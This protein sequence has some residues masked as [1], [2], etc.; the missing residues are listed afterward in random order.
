MPKRLIKIDVEKAVIYK[1]Q[2]PNCNLEHQQDE[3]PTKKT[4]LVCDS[5]CMRLGCGE[6]FKAEVYEGDSC[7]VL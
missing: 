2:C 5:E 6:E 1:W 3:E 4:I 7:G